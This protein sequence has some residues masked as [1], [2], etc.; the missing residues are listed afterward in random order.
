MKKL[1]VTGFIVLFFIAEAFSQNVGIGTNTPQFKLS[2]HDDSHGYIKFSNSTTTEGNTNGSF[3]GAFQ[4]DLYIWN[5]QQNGNQ[6]FYTDGTRRL[7]LD[8]TGRLGVGKWPES[9]FDVLGDM[10]LEST[11]SSAGAAIRFYGGTTGSSALYFYRNLSTPSLGGSLQ[12]NATNDYLL[13]SNGTGAYFTTD[14]MGISTSSPLSKLHVFSGQDAGLGN[15]TNGYLMLGSGTSS[16]IIFDNN[17]IMARNNGIAAPLTLQNDGGSVR[18]GNVAAP[19]GYLFAVN[20]KMIGE[21]LKV[22]LSGSWPDYVF[23]EDYQ[24]K[25]FDQLRSFIK[26]NNHLPNIPPAAEVEKNGIEVGDMQKRMVEKIEELTLYILELENRIKSLE[27]KNTI[28]TE[29]K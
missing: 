16:N 3:I 22:Q 5:K 2:V 6:F 12:Y 13:I 17:E 21:E 15:T 25:S 26:E 18:I 29:K 23:K 20:G 28:S 7:T 11:S 10:R 8:S 1:P 19:A 14:G 27:A 9:K 24:L 4:N